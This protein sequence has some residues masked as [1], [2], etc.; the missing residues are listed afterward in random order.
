[1]HKW[2]ILCPILLLDQAVVSGQQ[3]RLIS[4]TVTVAE[5]TTVALEGPLEWTI[6]PGATVVNNGLIS[7]GETAKIFEPVGGPITG[8]G[9][10]TAVLTAIVPYSNEEPGNL[11]LDL[12]SSSGPSPITVVRGHIPRE[13]PEGDSSIGRWFEL[14]SGPMVNGSIDV[15]LTY[16]PSELYGLPPGNLSLFSSGDMTGPWSLMASAPDVGSNSVSG[17]WFQ[18]GGYITAF[19]MDAP[20]PVPTLVV[21]NGFNVFPT[22]VNDVVHVVALDHQPIE[23]LELF[24]GIGRTV[25]V[26]PIR[27]GV[28]HVQVVLTGL[29]VGAYFLRLNNQHVFKLR[30]L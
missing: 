27:S 1:M 24:D 3:M 18:P 25:P 12:S 30:V 4:G 2:F 14:Q 7:L 6:D 19:D 13:F 17:N 16:D 22:V 15:V 9:T 26:D 23:S 8:A 20:T 10:E 11:G 5:G 28:D 21:Q 29:G